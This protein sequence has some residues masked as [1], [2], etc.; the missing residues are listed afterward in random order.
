VVAKFQK[1]EY[2]GAVM[3]A[4]KNSTH[5]KLGEQHLKEMDINA[6]GVEVRKNLKQTI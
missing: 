3:I 1:V 2:L 5:H 6:L 4:I